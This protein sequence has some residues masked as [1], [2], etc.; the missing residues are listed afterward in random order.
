[1]QL[2]FKTSLP[3]PEPLAKA[4]VLIFDRVFDQITSSGMSEIRS[5]IA[6]FHHKI[7]FSCGED[8]KDLKTFPE[9]LEKILALVNGVGAKNVQIIGLGGGS[10]GDFSGFT[11]SIIKRGLP[12]VHI[13]TTWLS[14]MD[15]AHGGKT[16][17]N[18]GGHKNQ[19]GTFYAAEKIVLIKSVLLRQPE[20]RAQEAF[21]EALK[22]ALLTGR[23]LWKRFSK[24]DAF[25]GH[26]AWKFLPDLVHEKYRIVAKDPLEKQGYR[27]F[28]NLGHTYG[29]VWEAALGLPHGRAVAFGIRASIEFSLSK[30]LMSRSDYTELHEAPVMKLLPSREELRE[31]ASRATKVRDYL[32]SDK[33]VASSGRVRFIFVQRPGKCLIKEVPIDDLVAFHSDL[34]D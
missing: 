20:A 31:V 23:D 25:A 1:M 12:L 33:K 26:V 30:K 14:A 17:L 29:H 28:L 11:A 7:G 9:K 15:S 32:V 5:W 4:S 19:V 18:V 3:H 13:P 24:L 16:A 6:K 22:M 27:H 10:L 8:L 2:Q 34:L 21:G